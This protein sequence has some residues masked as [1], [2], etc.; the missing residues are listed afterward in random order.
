[1]LIRIGT[2]TVWFRSAIW[3]KKTCT[4]GFFKTARVRKTS[5]MLFFQIAREIMLLLINIHE[6]YLPG[7]AYPLCKWHTLTGAKVVT[8]HKN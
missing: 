2:V 6:N 8:S 7:N 1:M 5:C 3:K 4:S